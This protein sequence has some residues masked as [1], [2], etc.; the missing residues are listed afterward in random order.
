MLRWVVVVARLDR[1]P[2]QATQNRGLVVGGRAASAR[3]TERR[4]IGVVL[5]THTRVGHTGAIALEDLAATCQAAIKP[6]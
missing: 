2:T 3:E 4:N 1:V 5:E 6:D